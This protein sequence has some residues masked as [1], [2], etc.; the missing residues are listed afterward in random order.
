[1]NVPGYFNETNEVT[2]TITLNGDQASGGSDDLSTTKIAVH[3]GFASEY[4]N[5]SITRSLEEIGLALLS[6]G[7]D[8]THT[9]T[10][11]NQDLI[12]RNGSVPT[13]KY[14]DFNIRFY[15]GSTDG[16]VDSDNDGVLD[17][18]GISVAAAVGNNAS[19]TIGGAL[20]SGGSCDFGSDG[21]IVTIVSA[22]DDAGISF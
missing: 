3:V 2:I 14:F 12:D 7:N 18:D 9:Y 20:A 10:I 17:A 4:N 5:I 19:L 6:T 8:N 1:M 11:T 15:D 21:R 13:N 16:W 22:G